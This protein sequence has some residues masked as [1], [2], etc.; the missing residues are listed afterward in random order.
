MLYFDGWDGLHLFSSE[1]DLSIKLLLFYFSI[2]A[3]FALAAT[4][5]SSFSIASSIRSL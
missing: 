1:N 5:L 2:P 3:I 4:L